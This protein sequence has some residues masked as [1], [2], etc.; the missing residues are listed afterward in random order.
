MLQCMRGIV[1]DVG[2]RLRH[3]LLLADIDGVPTHLRRGP[4]VWTSSGEV[5]P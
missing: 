1:G 5:A 4:D 3:Q 2:S